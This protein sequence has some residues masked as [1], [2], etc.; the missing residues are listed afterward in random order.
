MLIAI[1]VDVEDFGGVRRGTPGDV[2]VFML[3]FLLSLPLRV[4]HP[5]CSSN[6]PCFHAGLKEVDLPRVLFRKPRNRHEKMFTYI[7][8]QV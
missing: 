4:E 7:S 1:V 2:I 8:Y 6:V 5:E 3:P